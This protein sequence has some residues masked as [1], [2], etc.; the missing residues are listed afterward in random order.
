LDVFKLREQRVK[1]YRHH[2]QSFLTIKDDRVRGYVEGEVDESLL[3]PDP[4]LQLN[5]AFESGR[6]IDDL[7]GEGLLHTECEPRRSAVSPIGRLRRAIAVAWRD[8]VRSG[9]DD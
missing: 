2:A 7:V 3:W 4:L 1:D 9:A 5:P 8:G 6:Y